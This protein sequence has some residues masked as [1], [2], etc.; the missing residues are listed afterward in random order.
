[1]DG[2][3]ILSLIFLAFFLLPQNVNASKL[4][5]KGRQNPQTCTIY[6]TG[7]AVILG[8]EEFT[9]AEI[10]HVS[11]KHSKQ[12]LKIN[13]SPRSKKVLVTK[14]EK[15]NNLKNSADK[16]YFKP[17]NL[18]IVLSTENFL[19]N[20]TSDSKISVNVPNYIGKAIISECFSR[21]IK[22][23]GYYSLVF[24]SDQFSEL[25]PDSLHLSI[26]PPPVI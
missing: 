5:I 18:S 25:S 22:F 26:R 12:I 2:T 23:L 20:S 7:A 4:P 21:Y 13:D 19:A 6:I 15:Y 1:M 14:K 10:V 9:N 24:S 16:I 11:T 8:V 3:H 17:I